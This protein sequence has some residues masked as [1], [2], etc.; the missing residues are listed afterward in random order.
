[1]NSSPWC[2]YWKDNA[3]DTFDN[4][5]ANDPILKKAVIEFFRPHLVSL[6]NDTRLIDLGCGNG[7]NILLYKECFR[8]NTSFPEFWGVDYA[9]DRDNYMGEKSKFI[10][11]DFTN[12]PVE[13]GKYELITSLFGIEYAKPRQ[14]LS[15]LSQLCVK[16]GKFAFLLHDSDS[17]ITA[18]SKITVKFYDDYFTNIFPKNSLNKLSELSLSEIEKSL[19][20][21]LKN[22]MQ[23]L[24]NSLQYDCYIVAMKVKSYVDTAKRNNSTA[25]LLSDLESYIHQVNNHKARLT[26]QLA[27]TINAKLFTELCEE[28]NSPFRIESQVVHSELGLIGRGVI[29]YKK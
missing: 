25:K 24:P 16:N 9:A 1:M 14:L 18:K 10:K 8:D 27:S 19:L 11:G 3:S 26:Q 2:T 12:L 28:H 20:M 29:G 7:G 15:Q 13:T 5:Y 23:N 22:T 6:S 21:S 17:V 4:A